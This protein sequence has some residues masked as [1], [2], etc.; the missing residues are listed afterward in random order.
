MGLFKLA[1]LGAIVVSILPSDREQQ[2]KLYERASS[3]ATWT[4]TFCDRNAETCATAAGYWASFV[5]KAEFG[6][7]LAFDLVQDNQGA[8]QKSAD[9]TPRLIGRG[10]LRPE[11]LKPAWRGEKATR[12]GSLELR[13]N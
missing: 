6:A 1:V 9:G 3:A 11:D 12:V 4:M 13:Q 7:K 2:E 10:T 5:A 8:S